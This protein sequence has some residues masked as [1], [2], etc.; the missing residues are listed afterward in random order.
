MSAI[1]TNNGIRYRPRP[2]PVGHGPIAKVDLHKKL[3]RIAKEEV[4]RHI[5]TEGDEKCFNRF[6][7]LQSLESRLDTI[8]YDREFPTGDF[9]LNVR[10]VA[11]YLWCCV[12]L[13][14]GHRTDGDTYRGMPILD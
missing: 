13:A 6:T 8:M 14:E 3:L 10:A 12:S 7:Y 11:R 1:T 4:K 5:V 2:Q 9:E